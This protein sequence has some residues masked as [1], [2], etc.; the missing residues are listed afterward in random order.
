VCLQLSCGKTEFLPYI[1]D[2]EGKCIVV[3]NPGSLSE[4]VGLKSADKSSN[5]LITHLKKIFKKVETM[6]RKYVKE[7]FIADLRKARDSDRSKDPEEMKKVT[8]CCCC[9]NE[10]VR[11]CLYGGGT[12]MSQRDEQFHQTLN[13]EGSVSPS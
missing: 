2:A 4:S 12:K 11:H 9:H 13:L 6:N 1:L 3:D 8:F 7:K 5:S 10:P